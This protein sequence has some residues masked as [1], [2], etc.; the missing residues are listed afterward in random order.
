MKRMK[1]V[2]LIGAIACAAVM[3]AFIY[4]GCGG[5]N[6]GSSAPN[7]PAQAASPAPADGQVSRPQDQQ[8]SWSAATGAISYDIYFGITSTGWSVVATTTGLT[9]NP[10]AL[11]GPTDYYW[12]IDSRNS[13]GATAG[14]IWSFITGDFTPPTVVST[15]PV[16]SATNIAFNAVITATF[17]ESMTAS[18]ISPTT[19][20][21]I[22]DSG[23]VT[24]TVTCTGATITFTPSSLLVGGRIY[25]ATITTGTKDLADN[26]LTADYVWT[27]NTS[28]P[29][30]AYVA[31][32]GDNTISCYTIDATTG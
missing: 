19:F 17:S 3:M 15:G 22:H 18:S 28:Y 32:Y 27:F 4:A 2:T 26:N 13:G 12:R 11:S 23:N 24:G 14:L 9:Y 6:S 25:T 31:N 20:T 29:R 7:L 5:G 30:F 8:L 16:A 10:G 21:L 1:L